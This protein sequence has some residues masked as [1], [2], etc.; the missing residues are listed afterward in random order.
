MYFGLKSA[1]LGVRI[2]L[3]KIFS[4]ISKLP[5]NRFQLI[6]MFFGFDIAIVTYCTSYL[7]LVIVVRIC[8]NIQSFKSIKITKFIRST[9]SNWFLF[10]HIFVW[11]IW[12][13]HIVVGVVLDHLYV[14]ILSVVDLSI[15]P[16]FLK[17]YSNQIII[18][19]IKFI[20]GFN[21][22]PFQLNSWTVLWLLWLSSSSKFCRKFGFAHESGATWKIWNYSLAIHIYR[23]FGTA[24]FFLS[25]ELYRDHEWT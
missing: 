12:K 13:S 10:I 24:K 6:R 19:S 23:S 2:D 14:S 15:D 22:L 5:K 20:E 17:Y 9:Y 18:R 21:K 3:E 7:V 8:F 11:I 16:A 25:L 1:I 4:N